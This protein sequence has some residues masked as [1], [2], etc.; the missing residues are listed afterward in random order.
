[1]LSLAGT[2]WCKCFAKDFIELEREHIEFKYFMI[3]GG[4]ITRR[5]VRHFKLAK[6]FAQSKLWRG[7]T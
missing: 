1:M 6:S 5:I 3:R 2:R 7:I 4:A